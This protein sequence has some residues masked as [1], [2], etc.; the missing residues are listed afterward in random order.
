MKR[1]N[2]TLVLVGLALTTFLFFSSMK[3][4]DNIKDKFD[5]SEQVKNGVIGGDS[6]AHVSDTEETTP[7]VKSTSKAGEKAVESSDPKKV[8]TGKVYDLV[9]E[10]PS[11]PGGPAGLMKWLSSH[12]QY[13]AIAIDIC[14]Q[15]TVIVSFIVEPDGSVSNAKLVRSVDPCI[16]QEALRLV[17][18]MPKWNPG[19]R[20]GIPVRV[21]CCLPIKFKQGESKPSEKNK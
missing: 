4:I 16:D 14:I 17:G 12:V 18:Q 7:A 20:A 9:D 21:R 5:E 2:H 10:M 1:I 13:P 15:G 3:K 8:F 6:L 11:F 19:K